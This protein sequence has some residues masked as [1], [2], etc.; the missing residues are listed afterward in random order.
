MVVGLPPAAMQSVLDANIA[1]EDLASVR[2][3][4]AGT[5][6]VDP[7]LVD[8]F[9]QT[10]GI[11]VLIVYGATEFSGA[12]AGWTI[13]DFRAQWGAKHGSV[14]RA[15]PG[16]RLQVIDDEGV[17]LATGQTGRLQVAAPQA[18]NTTNGVSWVT[19]SD[20]AHLDEDGFLYIDGRADDVIIRGGFKIA[21]ESVSRALRLH[22]S[23]QDAG[24]VGWPD[25]RLGHI[26]VAAVELRSG[27]TATG[28][29]LRAHCR[30]T[31]TPY[32]VPAEV[33]IVDAL[34]RGAALKID[35]RAL[36]SLLEQLRRPPSA[37][38]H[39]TTATHHE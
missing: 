6:F 36:L 13:A 16:V 10:Y 17:V 28:A 5:S 20:L 8:A 23:V 14:G 29:D 2:A 37:D 7:A 26:P 15:F 38:G 4:N 12:V 18:S 35:R 22:P 27:T 33:H 31:L 21:P 30:Q 11:P 9:L 19:T 32:E 39:L 24:V 25:A 3:I 34:P 1:P